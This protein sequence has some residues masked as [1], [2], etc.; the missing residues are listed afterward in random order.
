MPAMALSRVGARVVE[1]GPGGEGLAPLRGSD[2]KRCL[3]HA[4]RRAGSTR[5][6]AWL[7][8]RSARSPRPG[9]TGSLRSGSGSSA[10]TG[11]IWPGCAPRGTRWPAGTGHRMRRRSGC[12]W[13]VLTPAPWPGPCSDRAR[14]VVGVPAGRLPT[15]CGYRAR[16]AVR[17]VKILAGAGLRPVAVNGK[18]AAEPAA[19]TARGSTCSASP[20]TAG[21]SWTTSR[22]A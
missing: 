17:Q 22:S 8:S 18:T 21:I 10:P 4:R 5:W 1:S 3:T 16:R 6:P 7:R 20:S 15:A 11:Q 19:P 13:T 12:S 9:M 2:W 14:A